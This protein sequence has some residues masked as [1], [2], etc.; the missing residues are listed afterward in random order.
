M[1]DDRVAELSE[2]LRLLLGRWWSECVVIAGRIT[3]IAIHF[4]LSI[5]DF[6]NRIFS[7]CRVAAW[8]RA[9]IVTG[10]AIIAVDAVVLGEESIFAHVFVDGLNLAVFGFTWRRLLDIRRHKN[11]VVRLILAFDDRGVDGRR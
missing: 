2:R 11:I 7:F 9:E 8:Q 6:I 1:I 5:I 4:L 10:V 3:S